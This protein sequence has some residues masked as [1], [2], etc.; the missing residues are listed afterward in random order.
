MLDFPAMGL[1]KEQLVCCLWYGWYI[2]VAARE[3][4]AFFCWCTICCLPC[5]CNSFLYLSLCWLVLCL[6]YTVFSLMVLS[7]LSFSW[8]F[9]AKCLQWCLLFSYL[10]SV[11][12]IFLTSPFILRRVT[13]RLFSYSSFLKELC[14]RI[15]EYLEVVDLVLFLTWGSNDVLLLFAS[16][17]LSSLEILGFSIL[18]FSSIC[19][20]G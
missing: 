20:V 4:A 2:L 7:V 1:V 13:R 10:Y 14:P 11:Y 18:E 3:E 6:I 17:F 16:L 15:L 12:H 9:G 5:Y 19:T 8:S